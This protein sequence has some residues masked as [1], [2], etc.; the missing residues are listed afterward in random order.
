MKFAPKLTALFISISA[1]IVAV[2][3]TIAYFQV[4]KILESEIRV[5]M[6][7]RVFFT[8]DALDRF[9]S[10]RLSDIKMIADDPVISSENAT[11]E[12]IIERLIFFRNAYKCY[13]S[14]SFFNL[15]RI[16]IADTA[17]IHIGQQ[18][19]MTRYWEDVLAGQVSAASDVRIQEELQMPIVYFASAVNNKEGRAIGVVV[20][21]IPTSRLFEMIK[22]SAGI[23]EEEEEEEEE[24]DII[25]KDGLLIYSNHN[26]GGIL[27]ENLPEWE[28]V[29]IAQREK[30]FGSAKHRHPDEKEVMLHAFCRERGCLDFKGN[31]WT[32]ISHVPTRAIL[33]PVNKLLKI[34]IIMFLAMLPG[35]AL[36]IYLFSKT[37]TRPLTR[38]SFAA[39]EVG[40]GKLDTVIE[41][42]SKDEIRTLAEAFNRM[43]EN[44]KNTTT[45]IVNLNRDITERKQFEEELQSLHKQ[46]EF[47]LGA[48]KTGL[49][50]IDSD[51]NMV[52][53]DPQWQKI[54]GEYKGKKCY[55][56]FMDR[57]QPCPGCGIPKAL[58][59]KELVVTEEIL[60]KE[61]NRPIQVTTIPFQDKEG[62]WMVAEVNAD[63][64][65]RKQTEEKL[66]ELNEEMRNAVAKLEEVN[67]ELKNFVYIASHDMREPLRKIT[68]FGAILRQSLKD[69]LSGDDAENL[70]FMID[71]AERMAKMIE[72]LLIYSR[73]STQAQPHQA[74]DLNEIVKQLQQLELSV[75]L[76]EK[77]ATIEIPQPLPCVEADPVQIRQLM[78]NLIA[79][80]VKY[81]KKGNAPHITITSKPAADGMVRIEVMDNGIGIAP[82]YLQSI[83]TM[84]RRLHSRDE[85]EGTGIGLAVCKK[86]VELHG[87]KISV[88]SQP[89]KG[90]TFWFTMPTAEK[91][92]IAA[93]EVESHV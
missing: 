27:K 82:Q 33:G 32:I 68:A 92:T 5:R 12:Q 72:G 47:I 16:R 21:R 63:I 62:K 29:K 3:L 39:A 84:F 69:K 83:F 7:N 18:H 87:G 44:L 22:G 67:G 17:G 70:H 88:E 8:M 57:D 36:V 65:E 55:E 64:T 11:A 14:L 85:Y 56:Y 23:Q 28:S 6:E 34:L 48:T 37:V 54:Y 40:K 49:D 41:V 20:A 59:T 77:H 76:E 35:L 89:D 71:G 25:N 51:F 61:G 81:Q 60:V 46:V 93:T 74:V 78:Q 13:A 10:E 90:S 38:L 26:R 4:A 9:L 15:E 50:I 42:K 30:I 91:L 2:M 58:E 80:G 86:I 1:I 75:L 24:I 31:D 66:K 53:I 19:Q 52:Y 79:N 73:I 45:S 43:L